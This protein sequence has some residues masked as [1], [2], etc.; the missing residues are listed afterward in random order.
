[1]F[2][3]VWLGAGGGAAETTG[4]GFVSVAAAGEDTLA[5]FVTGVEPGFNP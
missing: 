1:M 4:F 5:R 3:G 2:E